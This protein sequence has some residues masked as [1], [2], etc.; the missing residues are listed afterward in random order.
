[1]VLLKNTG[2]LPIKAGA[3]VAVVAASI[4]ISVLALLVLVKNQQHK[5][6]LYKMMPK[7]AVKK[8]SASGANRVGRGVTVPELLASHGWA[9][10]FRREDEAK[11]PLARAP[12]QQQGGGASPRR[13]NI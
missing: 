11:S 4:V 8:L 3:K 7:R 1:M 13:A 9:T 5:D 6:L 2:V 10:R 12:G